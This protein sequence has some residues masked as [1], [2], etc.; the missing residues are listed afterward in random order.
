MEKVSSNPK[1]SLEWFADQYGC[2]LPEKFDY[3]SRQGSPTGETY[4]RTADY[5]EILK[6]I[7]E[8]GK[9]EYGVYSSLCTYIDGKK[10]TLMHH[11][12]GLEEILKREGY[13]ESYRINTI[14]NWSIDESKTIHKDF[15]F[16]NSQ[17]DTGF[18]FAGVL[19]SKTNRESVL[20]L[21]NKFK[22]EQENAN[23]K[24]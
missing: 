10:V 5:T 3:L 23:Q 21:Y 18:D 8:S 4:T 9:K 16:G 1:G 15:Y 14:G 12:P 17:A 22:E 24:Q 13:E 6:D 19:A 2:E 7:A 11:I 20:N